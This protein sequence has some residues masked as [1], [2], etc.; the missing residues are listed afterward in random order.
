[1][2]E[3]TLKDNIIF[4]SFKDSTSLRIKILDF[5][6]NCK[7]DKILFKGDPLE[8][9]YKL[10]KKVLPEKDNN[11]IKDLDLDEQNLRI[12]FGKFVNKI[13]SKYCLIYKK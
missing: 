11:E 10:L 7:T 9:N 12:A 1:M 6:K 13:E 5:I 4:N 8:I 2:I 3:Y